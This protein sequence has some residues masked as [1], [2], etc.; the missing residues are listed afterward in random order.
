MLPN[1]SPEVDA[2]M[3]ALEHPMAAHVQRIRLA[4]LEREPRLTERIKWK[5]PSIAADDVDRVTFHLRPTDRVS[6]ILHRGVRTVDDAVPFA[7]VDDAGLVSWI[8]SERGQVTLAP[9][10][11]DDRLDDLLRLVH[12]WVRV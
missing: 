4:I 10:E 5:A 7:F 11:V 1:R 3:D 9:A 6:L 2:F 12:A 8:T